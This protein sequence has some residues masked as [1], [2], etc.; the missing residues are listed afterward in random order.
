MTWV[1]KNL[2]QTFENNKV[3]WKTSIIPSLV[4]SQ[5][6]PQFYPISILNYIP[7]SLEGG[8]FFKSA[9]KPPFTFWPLWLYGRWTHAADFAPLSIVWLRWHGGPVSIVHSACGIRSSKIIQKSKNQRDW[10]RFTVKM[11][12]VEH[13]FKISLHATAIQQGLTVIAIAILDW[14][15][16]RG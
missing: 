11:R 3:A 12:H 16:K 6:Q 9:K 10:K 15:P 2:G 14:C 1:R 4:S 8:V 7:V 13:A 5:N